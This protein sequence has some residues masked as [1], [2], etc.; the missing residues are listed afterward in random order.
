[1]FAK[2]VNELMNPN[3]DLRSGRVFG[4]KRKQQLVQV[5][6]A[7]D[8][9]TQ[10]METMKDSPVEV[11]KINT[12]EPKCDDEKEKEALYEREKEK[13]KEKEKEESYNV[14]DIIE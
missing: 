8:P 5:A 11:V 13:E 7:L 12:G 4:L 10:T 1:M 14:S 6:D 9:S 3:S 2:L